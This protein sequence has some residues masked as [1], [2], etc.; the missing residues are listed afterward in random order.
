MK[1]LNEGY[2]P[3]EI[4]KKLGPNPSVGVALSDKREEMWRPPTPPPYTAYSG[5]GTSMGG[6]TAIGG[7]VNKIDGKPVVDDSK[8]T[9]NIN[10]RFHNGERA[11]ITV[12]LTHTVADI[13][14]Y[15]MTAAPV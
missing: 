7:A 8:E 4:R 10:I 2:V 13:H 15:V 3:A 12:N 5:A 1:E 14:A 9:T 6:V 11:T